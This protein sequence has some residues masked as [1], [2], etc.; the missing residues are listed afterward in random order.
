MFFGRLN[1]RSITALTFPLVFPEP[2]WGPSHTATDHCRA[3]EVF[4]LHEG[5]VEREDG[6]RRGCAWA[7]T[8]LNLAVL[9]VD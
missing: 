4:A 6:R 5:L 2:V 7:L 3:S 9:S 8:E 1:A